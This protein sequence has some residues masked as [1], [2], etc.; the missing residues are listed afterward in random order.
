MKEDPLEV[1]HLQACGFIQQWVDDNAL[2]H[3]IDEKHARTLC[4]K[5]EELYAFKEGTNKML[6]IKKLWCL[7]YKEG[8][9][10]VDH[11]NEFHGIINQLSSV[12]ITFEDEDRALLLLGSLPDNWKTFKVTVSNSAPNGV[13]TWNLVKTK[14]LNGESKKLL[15]RMVLLHTQKCW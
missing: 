4:K 14:V 3:I 10:I 6:F 12:G 7:R 1:L 2:N 9:P 13:V 5:L 11:V 15:I 8:T